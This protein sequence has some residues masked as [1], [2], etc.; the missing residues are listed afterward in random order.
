MSERIV[1]G[2]RENALKRY[3]PP[4]DPLVLEATCNRKA[5]ALRDTI[6]REAESDP[7]L[8]LEQ[9]SQLAI[10]LLRSGRT[11]SEAA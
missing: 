9:R 3:R 8:S 7:P 5:A 11:P 10:L 1:A 6:R 2:R 4:N